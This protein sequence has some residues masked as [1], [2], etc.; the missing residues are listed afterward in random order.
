MH[1][2]L[3]TVSWVLLNTPSQKVGQAYWKIEMVHLG[4]DLNR[5]RSHK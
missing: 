1:L 4:L 2:K 5:T 3:S